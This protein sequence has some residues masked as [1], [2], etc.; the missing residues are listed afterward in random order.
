[1]LKIN[2][3]FFE[4]GIIGE[5]TGLNNLFLKKVELPPFL[6]TCNHNLGETAK[7]ANPA[8]KTLTKHYQYYKIRYHK[9][10]ELTKIRGDGSLPYAP[11]GKKLGFS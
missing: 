1:M 7:G 11:L 6:L 3:P 10:K 2:N 5:S 9:D 4:A 8:T